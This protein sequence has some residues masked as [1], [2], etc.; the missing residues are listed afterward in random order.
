MRDIGCETEYS[1]GILVCRLSGDIDHHTARLL[2]G[3]IDSELYLY[4]PETVILDLKDVTFMD[5]AGLGLILGR[6]TKIKE[7][8]GKLIVANPDDEADKILRLAGAEKLITIK[9]VERSRKSETD[10]K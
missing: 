10:N 7:L 9:K 1:E 3:S 8:G 5:S 2:R 4:R 6:H